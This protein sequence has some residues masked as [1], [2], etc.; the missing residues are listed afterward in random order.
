MKLVSAKTKL[1]RQGLLPSMALLAIIAIACGAAEEAAPAAEPAAA[2]EIAQP[3]ALEI[4]AT[5]APAPQESMAKPAE[6][7]GTQ[8]A[9]TMAKTTE[10]TDTKPAHDGAPAHGRPAGPG[11]KRQRQIGLRDQ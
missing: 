9:E 8:P 11:G 6:S 1:L 5:S 7:M 3:A 2:P 10:S 4:P